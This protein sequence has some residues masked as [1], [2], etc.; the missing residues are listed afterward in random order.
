MFKTLK[1]ISN[2]DSQSLFS[3][4]NNHTSSNGWKLELKKFN[5]SQCGNFFTHKVASYWSR[6]PAGVVN[7]TTINQFKNRLDRVLDM[8]V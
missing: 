1:G 5:T 8:L 3:L 7:G 4:N 2:V 6:L